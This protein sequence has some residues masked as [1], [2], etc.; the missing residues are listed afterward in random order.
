[1]ASFAD[2]AAE[3]QRRVR[4]AVLATVAT[5]D[6]QGRP[7]SRVLHP[8]WE[9]PTGWILTGRNS[10]KARHLARSP[11]VSVTYWD[12]E[13]EQVHVECRV[14]FKDDLATRRRLWELFKSTPPPQGYDPAPFF[15]NGPDAADFGCLELT[16]WRL[17]LWSTAALLSGEPPRVWRP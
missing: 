11:Y 13:Q 4:R 15:P 9:G 10:V 17:E 8:L 7:R 12:N 14:A 6:A 16:P 1:M 3:F 2:I 5:V